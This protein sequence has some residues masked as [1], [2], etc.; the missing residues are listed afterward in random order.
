MHR[1]RSAALALAL[2][3]CGEREPARPTPAPE[4][5][6]ASETAPQPEPVVEPEPSAPAE[7]EA[8][9][10]ERPLSAGSR[11]LVEAL[12]DG[13]ELTFVVTRGLPDWFSDWERVADAFADSYRQA[14]LR[15]RV[16]E[17]TDRT[18][19]EIEALGVRESLAHLPR[20]R[21]PA[22]VHRGIVVRRRGRARVIQGI[23]PWWVEYEIARALR[24]LVD[25]P[26]VI[27]IA[28]TARLRAARACLDGYDVENVD[29]ASPIDE[30][31]RAL[32]LIEPA[33]LSPTEVAHV[34]DYLARGGSVGVFGGRARARG[35]PWR[36]GVVDIVD[37]G[38]GPLLAE[39]GVSFTN[40][41]VASTNAS[42]M[43]IPFG[44]R[45]RPVWYPFAPLG[46][47]PEVAMHPALLR[48]TAPR[49]P[50]A[51][52]MAVV[53][54]EGIERD[55]VIS[56]RETWTTRELPEDL[57]PIAL[58]S[59]PTPADRTER[60]LAALLRRGWGSDRAA[61][62]F[63]SAADFV[64]DDLVAEEGCDVGPVAELNPR[65]T[66]ARIVDWLALEPDLIDIGASDRDA[67]N[68]F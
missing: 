35:V 59:L 5:Q 48:S 31:V 47:V 17:A 28:S 10:G 9:D 32:L 67:P 23:E 3:S 25:P 39:W 2:L 38:L 51:S 50:F 7:D 1:A 34:R 61:R 21:E 27:G 56:G 26:L 13:V 12:P 54:R 22:R 49:F 4:P 44:R 68:A 46:H 29:L 63:V 18:R 8:R 19:R 53:P 62:L 60:P 15:V 58:E 24:P 36:G 37:D 11:R 66:F 45:R 41:I 43:E 6:A 20:S 65:A 42:R 14:G 64:R 55:F 52:A 33:P 16:L 57:G 40:E 30:H